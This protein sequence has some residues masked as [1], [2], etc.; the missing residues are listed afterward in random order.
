MHGTPNPSHILVETDNLLATD[1]DVLPATVPQQKLRFP[2]NLVFLQ[3]PHTH[4]LMPAVDIRG[5]QHRVFARSRT[6][7]EFRLWE[8]SRQA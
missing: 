4:G 7:T 5:T 1:L 3:I 8:T 2:Q 6:D